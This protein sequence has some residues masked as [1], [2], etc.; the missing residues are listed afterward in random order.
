MEKLVLSIGERGCAMFSSQSSFLSEGP[1]ILALIVKV[2]EPVWSCA[3]FI[4]EILQVE[5]Y[6]NSDLNS[7]PPL[8]IMIVMM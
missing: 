4:L 8:V 1:S 3:L 2:T 7:L 6:M 5:G